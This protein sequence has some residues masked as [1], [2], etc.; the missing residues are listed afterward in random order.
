MAGQPAAYTDE[1]GSDEAGFRAIFDGAALAIVVGTLD[2][3]IIRA[4]PACERLFGYSVAELRRLTYPTLTHPDDAGADRALYAAL[5]AG[6]RDDYRIE[7]RYRRKDG[8][9]I[10]GRA[11]N[12]L[13]RDEAGAP[14]CTIG[15]VEDITD[16]RVGEARYRAVVEQAAEGIF[17]FDAASKRITEANP[18]FCAL[19][20]YTPAELTRLTLYDIVAHDRPSID[21]NTARVAAGG[22]HAIGDRLY[23]RKDGSLVLVEVSGTA[24]TLADGIAFSVVVRDVTERRQLEM[25]LRAVTENVPVILFTLDPAGVV[26]FAA[27]RALDALGLTPGQIVGR[28]IFAASRSPEVPGYVRRALAGE[29]FAVTVPIGDRLFDTHY[30]PQRNPDGGIAGVIGVATDITEQSRAQDELRWLRSGLTPRE[31]EVLPLLAR[32]ELTARQIG[33]LLHIEPSTVRTYIETIA[34][35]LGCDTTRKAV[36]VAARER[37][38][39]GPYSL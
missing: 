32:R 6:E 3:R 12:S 15:T 24:L 5:V 33:A 1:L 19:L 28:S 39:L 31:R 38:L 7:K 34:E 21:A 29:T 18:A 22:H 36:V 25:Q 16:L 27:G 35:K 8:R 37:G 20:G 26:T 11:T 10:W 30:A 4:N 17:L 2:R 13:V 14:V 23:L 9:L